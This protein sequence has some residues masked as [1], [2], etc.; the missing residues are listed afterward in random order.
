[1]YVGDW[2]KPTVSSALQVKGRRHRQRSSVRRKADSFT[3]HLNGQASYIRGQD[4]Q[5]VFDDSRS[6]WSNVQPAVGVKVADA[7]VRIEV[8]R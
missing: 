4:A 8:L 3:L 7:G 2:C 5:P 6:Y 1:M